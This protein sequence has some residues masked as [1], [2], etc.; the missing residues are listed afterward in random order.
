LNRSG[1]AAIMMGEN[2][3]FVFVAN[4]Q[5]CWEVGTSDPPT[6]QSVF[7]AEIGVRLG[8]LGAAV[9]DS[10]KTASFEINGPDERYFEFRLDA[11]AAG[12]DRFLLLTVI[13]LTEEYRREQRLRAL[14]RELNHR[15]KNLLAIILSVASQTARNVPT[16]ADFLVKFRGR[17][18]SISHSQDLITD[19]NWHGARFQDLVRSQADKYYE[20]PQDALSLHGSDP[21]LSPNEALHIG[22]AIHELFVDA[23]AL[24]EEGSSFPTIV[25]SCRDKTYEGEPGLE[26]EW[27]QMNPPGASGPDRD[28]ATLDGFHSAVLERITPTA[29]GGSADYSATDT[30]LRYRLH[31]PQLQ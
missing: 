29:V 12:S 16:L 24:G 27:R 23:I 5:D 1:V 26:I 10:G 18:Y 4:L 9:F 11:V 19:A 8:E 21:M 3:D 30:G 20:G 31:F 14:L 28:D 17:L 2:G 13:E 15:S 25:V 7:G 6:H 22:L